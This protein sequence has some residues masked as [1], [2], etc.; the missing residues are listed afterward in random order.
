MSFRKSRTAAGVTERSATD[1]SES[2][3]PSLPIAHVEAAWG[4]R[5]RQVG[6]GWMLTV[7]ERVVALACVYRSSG[8]FDPHGMINVAW[9]D[10][11]NVV[12]AA[13]DLR[14]PALVIVSWRDSVRYCDVTKIGPPWVLLSGL[15]PTVRI[16]AGRLEPVTQ[17]AR[18]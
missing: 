14:M 16:Q 10:W 2:D 7:H 11:T 4:C 8:D 3:G 17:G 5:L 12:P 9:A 1:S 6:R 15:T 13:R 18:W